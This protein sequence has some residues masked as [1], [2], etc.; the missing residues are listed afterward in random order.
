MTLRVLQLQTSV[1]AGSG[2]VIRDGTPVDF[3]K[4]VKASVHVKFTPTTRS[5]GKGYESRKQGHCRTG[6]TSFQSARTNSARSPNHCRMERV[7]LEDVQDWL[8]LRRREAKPGPQTTALWSK[9]KTAFTPHPTG[10]MLFRAGQDGDGTR[11]F[12]VS[13]VLGPARRRTVSGQAT[14]PKIPHR[15]RGQLPR[16]QIMTRNELQ[17]VE[18]PGDIIAHDG[19]GPDFLV[20]SSRKNQPKF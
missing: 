11:V 20:R 3:Q 14:S 9:E 5:V 12:T 1:S 10:T 2:Q 4:P 16:P 6:T 17:L 18:R 8:T 15:F 7:E 13:T 19:D